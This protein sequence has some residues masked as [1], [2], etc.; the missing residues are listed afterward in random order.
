[1]VNENQPLIFNA[2]YDTGSV[3]GCGDGEL[4]ITI[5]NSMLILSF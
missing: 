2:V 5:S 1:M 3:C 4:N